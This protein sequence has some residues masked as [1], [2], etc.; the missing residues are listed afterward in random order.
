[1]ALMLRDLGLSRQQELLPASC[2]DGTTVLKL[3]LMTGQC[4]HRTAICC[5]ICCRTHMLSTWQA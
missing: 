4:Q 3:V 5:H 2:R 1:M